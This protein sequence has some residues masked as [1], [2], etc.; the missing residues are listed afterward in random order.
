MNLMPTPF[1]TFRIA[2]AQG[3]ERVGKLCAL[4]FVGS[5][6]PCWFGPKHGAFAGTQHFAAQRAEPNALTKISFVNLRLR[7]IAPAAKNAPPQ[8]P[9]WLESVA[10]DVS[11]GAHQA[12]VGPKRWALN[13]LLMDK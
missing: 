2:S 6:P 13:P 12:T 5:Q 10:D 1:V 9:Y 4:P 8:R 7:K 11:S 3:T